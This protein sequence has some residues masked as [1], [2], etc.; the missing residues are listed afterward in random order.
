MSPAC[1]GMMRNIYPTT[2]R[3]YAA[4]PTPSN[5]NTM[6][7]YPQMNS[8]YAP[9]A[10]FSGMGSMGTSNMTTMQRQQFPMATDYNLMRLFK[11]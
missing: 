5:M 2:S 7:R 1:N 3:P 10:Q 4:Y 11:E 9:V 8:T 6:P